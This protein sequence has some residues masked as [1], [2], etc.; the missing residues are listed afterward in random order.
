MNWKELL[1]EYLDVTNLDRT[2]TLERLLDHMVATDK[3]KLKDIAE[4]LFPEN[5]GYFS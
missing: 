1:R 4:F 2:D 5:K 3:V